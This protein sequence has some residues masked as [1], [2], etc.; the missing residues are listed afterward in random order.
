MAGRTTLI[1]AHRINTIID[2]DEIYFIEN[3]RVSGHGSHTELLSDHLLYRQY[4]ENQF[5]K[6]EEA[7]LATE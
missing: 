4:F 2:A 5:A 7:E 1:I 3:G 6:S